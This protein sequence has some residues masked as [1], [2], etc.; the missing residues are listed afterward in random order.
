[1]KYILL[2][3]FLL[4]K[5]S[6]SNPSN[7]CNGMTIRNVGL[8]ILI[9]CNYKKYKNTF[10]ILKIRLMTQML[11]VNYQRT[12]FDNN[13]MGIFLKNVTGTPK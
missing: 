12:F 10:L 8:R 11:E 6:V 9:A 3:F 4:F 1:M 13:I 2:L 5:I 7:N